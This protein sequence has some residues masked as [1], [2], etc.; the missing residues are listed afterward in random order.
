MNGVRKLWG[1]GSSSQTPPPPPPPPETPPPSVSSARPSRAASPSE[2]SPITTTTQGLLIRKNKK[3]SS[4]ASVTDAG[5]GNDVTGSERSASASSSSPIVSPTRITSPSRKPVPNSIPGPGP[6]STSP[7]IPPLRPRTSTASEWKRTSGLLNIRDDLLMSLLT[8][9]AVVDSREC[10]ILSGEEV[11]ELKKEHQILKI[12]LVATQKKLKL[13]TKIRDAAL[14]LS[15]VNTAHKKVSKATDDQLETAERKVNAAQTEFWRVSERACEVER[16]LLEHR[17]GVLGY[18]VAK[19]ERKMMPSGDVDT[20]NRSSTFSSVTNTSTLSKA[21]F[22]GAHLFAGHADAQIPKAPPSV[23]DVIAL[24]DRLRAATEALSIANQK[25]AEMARELSHLRLEKEQ[26]ETTM[27]MELQTAEE[28]VAALEQE[29]PRFE[30]LNTKC[31]EL[32]EERVQWE[33]NKAQLAVREKEVERLERRLEVLEE[34]SGEAAEM[35]RVLSDVQAQCDEELQKKDKEIIALKAEWEEAR[36]EWD[37]EKAVMEED[38]LAELSALRDELEEAREEWEAERAVLEEDKLTRL[39]ALQDELD[40]A[41]AGGEARAELEEAIEALRTVVQLHSIQAS[42]DS[43][44]QDL[45]FSV[46]SHLETLSAVLQEHSDMHTRLEDELRVHAD[47]TE[48]LSKDL[49]VIRQERDNAH[50][51]ILSLESKIKELI[52]TVPSHNLPPIEYKGEAADIIA[53]L[54]PIWDILPAPELRATKLNSKR[55][56]RNTSSTSNPGGSSSSPSKNT[57]PSLSDMDVRALKSLYDVRS[58]ASP[59][60]DQSKG[61][62]TFSIEAFVARVQALVID[63]RALIER[64]IRFAQAHSLLKKNAERAQK[65]AQDSNTALETYQRQVTTLERQNVS[66]VLKQ[67]ALMD[68]IRE[69]QDAI[70]RAV[71]ERREME[72]RAADQAETCRQLEE[73]NDALSAKTLTLAEEAAEAPERIRRQLAECADALREAKEEIDAMRSS[74]QTQRI[75]LLDELNTVQTE[76]GNLRAQLRATKK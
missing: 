70:E 50:L 52:D 12:R 40:D 23:S 59:P 35:E 64:L 65:L 34:K 41:R 75:A 76:N 10:E 24:E 9:E 26:I 14:S 16:K 15:K 58:P 32:L 61:K 17:A 28:T 36:E 45:L 71:G 44:F 53:L 51:E 13:E 63:D 5:N 74:E 2:G 56:L 55:H 18:S 72:E 25:Q 43:T 19:M 68:E 6:S 20:P 49:D 21:R 7:R 1:G 31:Q 33:E 8:S 11:E 62:G 60:A 48:S 4:V 66:L 29:L 69:L 67:N 27:G 39:G 42:P 3:Q 47:Q 46:G 57:L 73:A 30:E 38:K 22:D 54:Q 37:A